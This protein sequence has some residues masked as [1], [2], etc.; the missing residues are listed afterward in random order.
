[1]TDTIQR[2]WAKD[3]AKRGNHQKNE[4]IPRIHGWVYDVGTGLV[5]DLKVTAE[6]HPIFI[7]DVSDSNPQ[8]AKCGCSIV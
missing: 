8:R 1:M 2:A 7:L 4:L 6:V 5:N 3:A